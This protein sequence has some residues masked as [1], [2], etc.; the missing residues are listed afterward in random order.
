MAIPPVV[1]PAWVAAH[2]GE[3]VLAD[4]RY[5]LDGRS[6]HDAYLAGH[7]PGAVFVDL[8]A[9]LAGPPGGAA[10]RH[11]LP[12]A[13]TF[14]AALAR[15][16]IASADLVV[17]YDDAGGCF[18]ARLVWMLRVTGH[19]AA[20]LDGGLAAW[21]APLETGEVRRSPT[22][23]VPAPWPADRLASTDQVDD[24]RTRPDAVL[25]DA[26]APERFRGDV[27]P[28]D[29]R[30]GHIPGA[31]SSPWAANLDATGRFHRPDALRAHFAALGA[32]EGTR[33]V[34]SCGSGVT[35]CH[36]LLALELAGVTG[37]AL[38]P[39]SWSGWCA[40]PA[41]PAALGDA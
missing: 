15:R 31:R 22:T 13:E 38:F 11:P 32:R 36:T 14:A 30:A 7:L 18:A 4:V 25:L 20:L 9:D 10:G 34:V 19:R 23:R 3:L 26:R 8:D 39:A 33:L 35:A 40:D 5:F 37:A 29:P 27:E 1:A 16:G 6:G 24:L 12:T 41:R 2:R 17:A 21:A 28:L